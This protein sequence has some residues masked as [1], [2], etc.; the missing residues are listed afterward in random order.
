MKL[1]SKWTAGLAA[2]LF[3]GTAQANLIIESI[4][5]TMVHTN[6]NSRD[7]SGGMSAEDA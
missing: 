2:L 6:Y 1:K 5:L 7:L 4:V 3:A